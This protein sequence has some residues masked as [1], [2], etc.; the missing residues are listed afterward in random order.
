MNA[1]RP[2]ANE[3]RGDRLRDAD[4]GSTM[5]LSDLPPSTLHRG[6]LRHVDDGIGVH[7]SRLPLNTVR[8]FGPPMRDQPCI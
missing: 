4:E 6:G 3:L 2:P 7:A 5:H 8:W 1:S